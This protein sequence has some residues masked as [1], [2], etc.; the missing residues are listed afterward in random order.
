MRH[1]VSALAVALFASSCSG[2]LGG[3]SRGGSDPLQGGSSDSGHPA[4][5][6]VW[7]VGGGFCTGTLIASDVVLT[8]G[9]CVAD[10][11]Q[12]FYTGKGTPTSDPGTP[13]ADMTA[14]AV[15]DQVA[16]PSYVAGTCPNTTFDIGLL[17][18]SAPIDGVTPVAFNQ[19][20]APATGATCTAVGFGT[21]NEG[22]TVTY[23]EKRSGT[24]VVQTIASTSIQVEIGTALA[25]H[26]DSGGPL[27]CDNKIA[28]ATSC[29]TDGD[30]P[31]HKL[32]HYARIDPAAAWIKSTIDGWHGG[33]GTT[34]GGTTGGGTTGGGTTGGGT[35]GGG[36]TGGG[37]TGGTA[38]CS[39]PICGAGVKLAH[40]CD[41]C[42]TKICAA[43]PYCCKN[44]WDDQCVAEVGSLCGQSCGGGSGNSCSHPLCS[45]GG[46]LTKT[47]DACVTKICASDAYCCSTTW[48]DQCVGEVSS[49]CG[50][51]C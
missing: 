27:I 43:D 40:T 17:H 31:D 13:P 23:E 3:P 36:T 19:G 8:A 38:M 39:H 28:G 21:H 45:T 47:C 11:V 35:T 7:F 46:K 33:G 9:H 20:S 2:E 42:A 10:P 6:L 41:P 12:S 50:E 14:H 1:L 44:K 29:H 18:L 32:E 37:T 48:D 4:V 24:E 15:A 34:G 51:S 49:I 16:H 22:T 5:G 26:G 30:F 25:D